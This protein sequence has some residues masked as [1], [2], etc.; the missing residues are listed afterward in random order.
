MA[1]GKRRKGRRQEL[2]VAASEI[3]APGNP[4]YRALNRLL[5]EQ[6]VDDFAEESAAHSVRRSAVG[7]AF[8]PGC[9]SGC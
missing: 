4:F 5:E 9:I 6:D 3:R 1:I 8:R 7:R 2:F